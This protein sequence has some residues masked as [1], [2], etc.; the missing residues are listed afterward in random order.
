MTA[1]VCACFMLYYFEIKQMEK[2]KDKSYGSWTLVQLRK[3]LA[4]RRAKVSGRKHELIARSVYVCV[5]SLLS[6]VYRMYSLRAVLT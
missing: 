2:I 6:L 3:E 4:G 5:C 1:Y